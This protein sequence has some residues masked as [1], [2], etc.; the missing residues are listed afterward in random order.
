MANKNILQNGV[1]GELTL[2]DITK[3][4]PLYHRPA[5]PRGGDKLATVRGLMKYGFS[6]E[7]TSSNGGNM[8]GP[9]VYSVFDLGSTEGKG[10]GTIIVKLYLLGGLKGFLI[11]NK[12]KAREVYGRGWRIEDQIRNLCPEHIADRLLS[13]HH[14]GM[15]E[16]M[17]DRSAQYAKVFCDVIGYDINKTKIRGF[18]FTG[19][20]DGNVCVI[21][22]F[23]DAI[24][25]S[26]STDGGKTWTR[27]ITKELIYRAGHNI[28]VDAQLKNVQDGNGKQMFDDVADRSINGYVLVYKNDKCNYYEVATNKMI[29]NVWFDFGGNF[30][31][32][33]RASVIYNGE[34][35]YI[36]KG[37]DGKF[38]VDDADE[39]PICYLN[40]LP[41]NEIMENK[42]IV[43][44]NRNDIRNMVLEATRVMLNEHV[45][46]IYNIDTA[47]KLIEEQWKSPDDFWYVYISQR[48]KD[49]L[50]TFKKNHGA[51]G[52]HNFRVNF[53]AWGVVSGNTKEEAIESLKNIKMN[54]NYDYQNDVS[55]RGKK[56]QSLQSKSY[57]LQSVIY[58]CNKFNARCYMTINKRSMVETN[59]YADYLKQKGSER[60]REF[61]FAAGAQ[62]QY[63]DATN[64]WTEKRPFGLIDCDIDDVQ[65]QQ[66]LEDYLAKN[67]IKIFA[68]YE[69]HDGMHYLLPNRDAAKLDFKGFD[70]KYRPVNATVTRRASDPMVTFKGDACLLLYSACGY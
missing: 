2:A 6:R 1:K 61:Q 32:E 55:S 70:V 17:G 47:I 23:S 22:D 21:R 10:Y 49:N 62:K 48:K 54:I 58:L 46:E 24:P 11:F 3:G 43:K 38:W 59:Q 12:D 5:D 19:G 4:I 7:Y 64:K 56:I 18:V 13:R 30:N 42:N 27:G 26:Y 29:S 28:D 25:Y 53:I 8:Y 20:H 41:N 36:Y 45:D 69:S 16:Y 67:N 68:K 33:G 51:A 63:D 66:E 60:Y 39:C 57:P 35:Y 9:G 14:F 37:E 65:A 52:S 40:D 31:E 50:T 34:K 15:G 44:I